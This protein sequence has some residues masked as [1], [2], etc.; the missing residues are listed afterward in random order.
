MK[1]SI[2]YNVIFS[3]VDIVLSGEPLFNSNEVKDGILAL[4]QALT[5]LSAAVKVMDDPFIQE[6]LGK[7]TCLAF[8]TC[9]HHFLHVPDDN[10]KVFEM[11]KN[12]T[13]IGDFLMQNGGLT[14]GETD[15]LINATLKLANI[16]IDFGG[17]ALKP[18]A[19]QPEKLAN[20]LIT[21]E[22][23]AV[24]AISQALCNLDND[25]INQLVDLIQTNIDIE[26]LI[27]RGENLVNKTS[28]YGPAKITNDVTLIIQAILNMTIFQD[29]TSV[30][31][32]L[33]TSLWRDDFE[34]FLASM[35]DSNQEV[36]YQ[37]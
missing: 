26:S 18:V 29:M 8:Q 31:T 27:Q 9:S 5:F 24:L 17:Q 22:T 10:V 33:N 32:V 7:F 11:L 13:R 3:F 12:T 30:P 15:K 2:F 6:I 4:P 36:D 23:E 34:S 28:S 37:M 14:S 20:Y 1:S 19:C 25:Q 21:D 35:L 16:F